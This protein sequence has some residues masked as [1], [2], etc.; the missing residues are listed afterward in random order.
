MW[1]V[2]PLTWISN[3]SQDSK[4]R[5]DFKSNLISAIGNFSKSQHL[6]SYVSCHNAMAYDT[7]MV[8]Y[9]SNMG[10]RLAVGHLGCMDLS[11]QFYV[12]EVSIDENNFQCNNNIYCCDK[13]YIWTG[14]WRWSGCVYSGTLVGQWISWW[15]DFFVACCVPQETVLP[16]SPLAYF[17]G[18]YLS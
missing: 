13:F 15:D 8:S 14:W 18:N 9:R 12:W 11:G 17:S 16:Y 7:A 2:L 6:A 1:C 10:H 5:F 4:I 3:L